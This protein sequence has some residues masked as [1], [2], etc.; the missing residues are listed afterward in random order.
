MNDNIDAYLTRYSGFVQMLPNETFLQITN[1]DTDIAFGGNIQVELIDSCQNV[2]KTLEVNENF[3]L[4]EFTDIRGIKQI[5][6]EFGNI[7]QD[8]EGEL[9]FLKLTHTVSD[10][11]W[12]SAG[13]LLTYALAKETTR[14]KYKNLNYFRGISYD[15]Q[16]FFQ[17]IR[18]TCFKNDVDSSIEDEEYTQMS[19]AVISLRP[20]ITPINKY[21]FYTLDFFTY[22]RLVT[23][24][25][26][27]IIY[28][29][30]YKISNKPKPTKGDRIED[31]NIFE[32]TFEANPTEDYSSL[33]YQIYQ[34]LE[35]IDRTPIN[36]SVLT[37]TD[38]LY[39]LEFNKP[40]GLVSGI[41]AKLY[42]DGDLVSTITPT[43]ADTNVLSLDFSAYEFS[44]GNYSIVV[45]EAK[46]YSS[47]TLIP[48]FWDGYL[49]GDWTFTV[50]NSEITI[51]SVTD[52]GGSN[53]EINFT[54]NFSF[55]SLFSQVMTDELG[56][57]STSVLF[58]GVSSP[59]T[60]NVSLSGTNRKIRIFAVN[61][62]NSL[63][64][65]SNEFNF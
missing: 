9:I 55:I 39:L 65:F 15:N 7:G 63:T 4:N 60:R 29:E 5:A 37:T 44:N 23:L 64:V 54:S 34:P 49:F 53:Y 21:L 17:T 61:P 62:A 8:F 19:G 14:F 51:T 35:V 20:I 12:Y 36:L 22:N 30:D 24:L 28:I 45:D 11:V 26:H 42:K 10:D 32:C 50:D 57:W 25:M 18:L 43:I 41:T 38:G 48:E 40:I 6:Y 27:D 2:V 52:L 13:F 46:V 47:S 31:T 56:H 33:K 59:Q 1:C 58:S 16:N 3:F